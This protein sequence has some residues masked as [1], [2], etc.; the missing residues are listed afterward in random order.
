M[1]KADPGHFKGGL[2]SA[3]FHFFDIMPFINTD[4]QA[5]PH[6]KNI[7]R[8]D[9][10]KFTPERSTLLLMFCPILNDDA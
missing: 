6:P 7:V 8:I 4:P 5:F 1:K 3:L 9:V 2:L 10:E